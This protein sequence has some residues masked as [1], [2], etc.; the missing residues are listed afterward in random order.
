MAAYIYVDPLKYVY[1]LRMLERR[2]EALCHW[3]A[4]LVHPEHLAFPLSV[5][6]LLLQ[7]LQDAEEFQ[8]DPAGTI[9]RWIEEEDRMGTDSEPGHA[10]PSGSSVESEFTGEL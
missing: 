7:R 8:K 10:N 6:R 9:R 4:G 5:V 1:D 3:D 2:L